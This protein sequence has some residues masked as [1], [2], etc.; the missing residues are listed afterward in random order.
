MTD[1]S[2]GLLAIRAYSPYGGVIWQ[3]RW[4]EETVGA[5]SRKVGTIVKEL[6]AVVPTIVERR[7]E[8]RKQAELEHLGWEAE[9]RERERLERE[10]RYE[11]AVKESREQLRSIVNACRFKR[12]NQS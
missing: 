5:L 2:R 4:R 12:F 11:A 7:E 9:C 3:Q 6:E 8:A 1:V 10:R